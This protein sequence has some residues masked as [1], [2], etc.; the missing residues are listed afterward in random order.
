MYNSLQVGF[1]AESESNLNVSDT[2]LKPD[3]KPDTTADKETLTAP[4][5]AAEVT[6]SAGNNTA[7]AESTLPQAKED[8]PTETST[9]EAAPVNPPANRQDSP[10][11]TEK[12]VEVAAVPQP[13][14]SEP[15]SAANNASEKAEAS[16]LPD[17]GN[18]SDQPAP[19]TSDA[20]PSRAGVTSVLSSE[21]V[22]SARATSTSTDFRSFFTPG[23]T[24]GEG[25]VK[26][27]YL[28]LPRT[29]TG[30]IAN[31][32]PSPGTARLTSAWKLRWKIADET[33]IMAVED[34]I[35]IGRA[36]EGDTS[37]GFDLTPHGAYHFGASRMHAVLTMN[38]GFLYLEDL[39]STN[40][41]RINGF[42]V[43][44]KQKYRLRDGDEIE[45]A[46]LRTTIKF[47]NPNR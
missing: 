4:Q 27:D 37:I 32:A 12:S 29:D 31:R 30:D 41:T 44:P 15:A 18:L 23:K 45:F 38:D 2:P 34:R 43:T 10:E 21:T 25:R 46:R 22:D 5:E 19:A 26:T 1:S 3:N 40:G 33:I 39:N 13:A 6:N 9:Q 28:N 24:E 36:M 42:Q 14:N 16:K 17:T 20:P 35:V 11:T 7:P 8:K 47:E